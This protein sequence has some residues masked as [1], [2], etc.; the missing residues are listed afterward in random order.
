MIQQNSE[1]A[2]HHKITMVTIEQITPLLVYENIPAA[3]DFLVEAFGFDAGGVEHDAEGRPIHAEV[4]ADSQVIWLHQVSAD[5]NLV[6][7]RA[8]DLASSGLVIRVDDVDAHFEQA[9]AHGARI[10]DEPED[11]PYGQREYGAR[12][13]E[14]H[15]WW[16]TTRLT[17]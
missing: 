16:F 6:S 9:R 17:E 5:R 1:E 3:H 12:D 7:P 8:M 14:D 13:L 4:Y 2:A 11:K 15:W 10:E